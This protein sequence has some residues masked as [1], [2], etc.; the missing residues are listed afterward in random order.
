ML[1]AVHTNH[2]LLLS[3]GSDTRSLSGALEANLGAH[4]TAT[5][6]PK[7]CL[8]L[9]YRE[10]FNL[11]VL[12]DSFTESRS[13]EADAIFE[14]AGSTPVLEVNSVI[15]NRERIIRQA[16]STLARR[17]RDRQQAG[18]AAALQLRGELSSAVSGLLLQTQLLAERSGPVPA[19]ALRHLAILTE[20]L[21]ERLRGEKQIPHDAICIP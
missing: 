6:C 14:A 18:V 12:E 16:R 17:A 8:Q 1:T 13:T 4:V 3:G 11:V 10:T 19:G 5:D 21:S 2:L 15:A 7:H 9:L 20:A